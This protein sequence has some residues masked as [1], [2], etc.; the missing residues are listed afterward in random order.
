M[1]GNQIEFLADGD[2]WSVAHTPAVQLLKC[3]SMRFVCTLRR[4]HDV[5]F[6]K[7]EYYLTLS[8]L[9]SG[10]IIWDLFGWTEEQ[11]CRTKS[12]NAST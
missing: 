1:T 8:N 6:S 4:K 7:S 2:L 9:T 12:M 11:V 10:F 3:S 5:R